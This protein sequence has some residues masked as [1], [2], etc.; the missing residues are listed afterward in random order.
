MSLR[1]RDLLDAVEWVAADQDGLI[2][3]AQLSEIGIQR[4][5]LGRYVRTGGRWQRVLPGLYHVGMGAL[6][7]EQR[8]LAGLLFAGPGAQLTGVPALR[9]WGLEYLPSD[10]L[11]TPVHTLIPNERHRKS[12][13]F[14]IVERT[15]RLPTA[16]DLDGLPCAP[17]TRAIVDAGR[18]LTN[19]N[20][21]RALLLESVQRRMVEIPDIAAELGR[22]Q[23]RGTALLG[24]ALVEACAGV[25][26]VPEAEFR[27]L[28]GR[29]DLPTPL[30]NPELFLPNG[31]FFAQPDGL[32]KES[33]TVIEVESE[34]HHSQGDDW[35]RTL[36]RAT[37]FASVGLV[38][39]HVVPSK[40]RRDPSQVI[41]EIRGSHAYALTRPRPNLLIRPIDSN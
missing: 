37:R 17:L 26:S 23:R 13:G 20:L 38:A 29:T 10:P 24:D 30:W 34:R 28:I 39:V 2:T 32:I 14:V 5:T 19:R 12:A 21:T 25:R 41:R 16:V 27:D 9:R 40:M 7:L 11:T 4:S 15:R 1:T 22:A 36:E 33:M 8:E 18:R 3:A 35:M 6:S 31:T